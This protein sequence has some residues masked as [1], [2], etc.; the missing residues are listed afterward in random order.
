M[1]TLNEIQNIAA[2][3]GACQRSAK[4]AWVN[5]TG[6]VCYGTARHVCR[7]ERGNFAHG[8]DLPEGLFVRI[9]TLD[10]FEAFLPLIEVAAW[11]DQGLFVVDVSVPG[12]VGT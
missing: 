10:G 5:L 4:V 7:D 9:T 11:H 6:G 2:I 1:T 3:L 12:P 8:D